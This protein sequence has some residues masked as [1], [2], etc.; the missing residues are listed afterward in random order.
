MLQTASVQLATS[1]L[2]VTSVARTD[3]S[4]AALH[5][6]IPER[7]RAM[8]HMVQLDWSEQDAFLAGIQSHIESTEPP[9]LV[10]A[11]IHNDKLALRLASTLGKF[12]LAFFHVIGSATSNPARVASRVSSAL[13][14]SASIQYYQ[15]V[16]G[17]AKDGGHV[18]WL[19][20]AEISAGVLKAIQSHRP[21]F[22]VGA[23]GLD[24]AE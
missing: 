3:R 16:L 1:S 8:H 7:Q 23:L 13:Q 14:P 19:T 9:D 20:H 18:R 4:L 21:Q 2:Q 5:S 6:L 12:Q 15:V 22:V 10:L 17:A 24:A 11:W